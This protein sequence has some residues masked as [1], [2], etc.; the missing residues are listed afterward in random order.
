MSWQ[1]KL[2][3]AAWATLVR[4]RRALR[5]RNLVNAG[6]LLAMIGGAYAVYRWDQERLKPFEVLAVEPDGADVVGAMQLYIRK[7]RIA[8][9]RGSW[10]IA[11]DMWLYRR[12]GSVTHLDSGFMMGLNGA[13]THEL[14][15]YIDPQDQVLVRWD[16]GWS[17][18]ESRFARPK[19]MLDRSIAQTSGWAFRRQK[20]TPG[21]P[22]IVWA[23]AWSDSKQNSTPDLFS[24]AVNGSWRTDAENVVITTLTVYPSTPGG[25]TP[26]TTRPAITFR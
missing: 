21:L 15:Y 2:V 26:P 22:L 18:S 10:Q 1:T 16:R 24:G 19:G 25:V 17:S 13:E 3:R 11:T 9:S 8:L 20:L 4:A 23:N 14:I 5:P 7:W 6:L 12:D